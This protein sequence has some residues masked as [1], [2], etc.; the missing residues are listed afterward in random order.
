MTVDAS[1]IPRESIED[2]KPR[3][4]ALLHEKPEH[5][6]GAQRPHPM[7]VRKKRVTVRKRRRR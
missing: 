5:V 3:I 2:F 7:L 6:T 4:A 1:E